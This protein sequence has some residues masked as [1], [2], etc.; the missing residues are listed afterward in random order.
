VY[1]WNSTE[2]LPDRIGEAQVLLE[3]NTDFSTSAMTAQELAAVVNS[4]KSGAISQDTMLEL[5][6]KGEILPDGRSNEEEARLIAGESTTKHT[7]DT[8]E[9]KKPDDLTAKGAKS[10]EGKEERSHL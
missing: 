9:E 6:R 1:W 8:K 3:L 2:E 4:W 5:F 7:K 10:A